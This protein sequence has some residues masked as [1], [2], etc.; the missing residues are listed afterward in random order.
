MRAT[1]NIAAGGQG[2][3][4]SIIITPMLDMA[5]QL[6]AFFV[7]TYHPHALEGHIDGKLLPPSKAQT[8]G[9]KAKAPDEAPINPE[10]EKE[11]KDNFIVVVKSVPKG[12]K[13]GSRLEGEPTRILLKRP[14][15]LSSPDTI[16]DTDTDFKVGLRKLKEELERIHNS[17]STAKAGV[18]IEADPDLH[19]QYVVA[20]YDTAKA[21][22]IASIGFVAPPLNIQGQ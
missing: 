12:K 7:M 16:A 20:V 21:A 19:Q 18:N 13:E 4:L 10:D 3:N 5:F 2:V 1:T 9:D 6:L 8:A 11:G 15:N 22:G 14:E 17:P